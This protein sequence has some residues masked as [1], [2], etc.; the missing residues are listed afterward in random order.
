MK[1]IRVRRFECKRCGFKC[2]RDKA[3]L[4]ERCQM[5]Q[6]VVLDK[7]FDGNE[8]KLDEY[9]KMKLMWY[10]YPKYWEYHIKN[11]KTINDK[12]YITKGETRI[13]EIPTLVE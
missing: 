12:A 13:G 9:S 10:K 2:I 6:D 3:A 7:D 8:R 1:A 4:V 5:C 11:R